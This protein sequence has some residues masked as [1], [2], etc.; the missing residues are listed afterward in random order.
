[1][2]VARM[3]DDARSALCAIL[4]GAPAAISTVPREALVAAA[5]AGRVEL[6]L[7]ARQPGSDLAGEMRDAVAL[8][9]ARE[10]DVRRLV[11]ALA[12]A[13]VRPV[14]IKG[15]ALAYTHYPRPD[16]R[17][18]VDTDLII[19]AE[20]RS[21]AAA[22]LESHGY[23]RAV[24]TDGE[25]CVSQ[26]HF[27]RAAAASGRHAIDVH[28][29]M[30]NVLAFADVLTYADLARD[31]VALPRLGPQAL[32]PS[33]LHS[34]LLACVHR[35]AHHDNSTQL[36]WL[37]DIHVLT[38]ALDDRQRDQFIAIAA[39]RRVAAV[40]AA[41]L[42]AAAEAFGG[43]AGDLAARLD[44]APQTI[45]PTAALLER[46]RR[47]VDVLAADI[48]ALDGWRA[49]ARLLWEHV[50]P[51]PTYM[52]ARYGTNRPLPWVYLRRIV[53]G[54]PKWLRP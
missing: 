51:A 15:A 32:G 54:A 16:L 25:W 8:E 45:E 29:R 41:G 35:V 6:L 24:E 2:I 30:S 39:A 4:S 12:A 42:H 3:A 37:Y 50:F 7:A 31:A 5:R 1:M 22:V 47:L 48:R 27:E 14:L 53:M 18:R 33:T 19:P 28:W 9:A 34:L 23:A 17:P 40:C 21:R 49:R 46:D 20:A 36:L 11:E 10:I 43:Q 13:G 52:R 38:E 26:M 44:A